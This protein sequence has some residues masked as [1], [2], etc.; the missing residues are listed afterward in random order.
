MPYWVYI[1]QGSAWVPTKSFLHQSAAW[2]WIC[3]QEELW[4]SQ[5]IPVPA[6]RVFR[7]RFIG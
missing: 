1:Q 3:E 2:L 5:G 4:R 7:F 6:Y